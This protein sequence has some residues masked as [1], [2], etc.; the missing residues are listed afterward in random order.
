MIGAI[1]DDRD[2]YPWIIEQPD[3]DGDLL[4][5]HLKPILIAVIAI[6]A[7]L[8]VIFVV[9]KRR[10]QGYTQTRRSEYSSPRDMADQ[11]GT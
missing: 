5:D 2:N 6:F 3:D 1:S 10:I 4:S 8:V 7:I 9:R 11:K